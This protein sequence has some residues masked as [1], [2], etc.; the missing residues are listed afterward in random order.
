M[1]MLDLFSGIGGF[2]LAASWSGIETVAFCEKDKFCR[3]VLKKHWP[4]VPAFYDIRRLNAK[5]VNER[6]GPIDIIAGGVPCQPASQ[7][8]QRKGN[9]DDRWLWQDAFR[10]TREI[11]PTWCIFENV[12]GLLTLDEGVAFEN[13]L[14]ELESIG[15]ETQA[16]IIPACAVN[17]PHRRERVWIVA[18]TT[19]R[20]VRCRGA[21]REARQPSCFGE[22][23]ANTKINN[24]G[25][26]P[27]REE[28][29]KPRFTF[30]SQ[31]VCNSTKPGF[32]DRTSSE[33]GKKGSIKKP[34]RSNRGA[35]ESR[36]GRLVDGIP[37]RLDGHWNSEPE[38]IPRTAKGIENRVSRLKALGNAIVPQV[39][40]RLF[41]K[42]MEVER[43]E[44]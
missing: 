8:G 18:N 27:K 43:M 39:A 40:Y 24:A 25:R 41:K 34:E 31:D 11:R 22:N 23:V 38:E 7:A 26:L 21:Q 35:V 2:S 12:Y 9:Q 44:S 29:E 15:Y 32:S 10:I 5:K 1:K 36:M 30:G 37:T 28:A 17:A 3:Q 4:D 20:G 19:Q 33:M 14:L 42:I 16:F 6:Y 13:L